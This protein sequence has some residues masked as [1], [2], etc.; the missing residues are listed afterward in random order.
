MHCRETERT[1]IPPEFGDLIGFKFWAQDPDAGGASRHLGLSG[2]KERAY[3]SGI[4]NL[5]DRFARTL[6]E[7]KATQKPEAGSVAADSVFLARSTDDLDRNLPGYAISSGTAA[8][9]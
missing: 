5:S 3:L 1:A 7:I 8:R 9:S 6:K 2:V 4:I